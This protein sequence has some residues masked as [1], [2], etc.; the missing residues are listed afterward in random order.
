MTAATCASSSCQPNDGMP[1]AV[2]SAAVATLRAPRRMT[3][4]SVVGSLERTSEE[5]AS[6]GKSCGTPL[7]SS[8]WQAEH[9]SR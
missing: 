8:P 5:S 2:G 6:D 3:R 9:W 1:G 7:P 4:I